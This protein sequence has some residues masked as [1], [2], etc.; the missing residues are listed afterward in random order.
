[1]SYDGASNTNRTVSYEMLPLQTAN[2]NI[3]TSKR[4]MPSA[5]LIC[6]G[7]LLFSTIGLLCATLFQT[8]AVKMTI[9]NI[10]SVNEEQDEAISSL[11]SEH[12]DDHDKVIKRTSKC[13]AVIT[14]TCVVCAATNILCTKKLAYEISIKSFLEAQYCCF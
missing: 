7:V 8:T 3:G 10:A 4:C 9:E 5:R 14:S 12:Q 13:C 2:T 1:M 6:G 11:K